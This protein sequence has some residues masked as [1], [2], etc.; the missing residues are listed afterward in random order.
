[1]V[2]ARVSTRGL[3]DEPHARL[4]PGVV[5]R[6]VLRKE[7]AVLLRGRGRFVDDVRVEGALEAAMLRSPFGHARIAHIDVSAAS[8]LPGVHVVVVAADLPGG[9]PPIPMRMYSRPGMERFL[10]RPLAATAVRYVG[11]PVAVVVADSRYL[12]EDALDLIEVDYEPL[13]A[14]VDAEAALAAGAPLLHAGAGT[15]LV[16]A[17]EIVHG[18][19][20]AAFAGAAHVV[21]AAIRC[22]RHAAVPL[23]TRGLLALVAPDGR[24][25]VHGPT[26][27][28]HTNRRILAG[29]L[30]WPEERIR[31]VE[32]HV[33]GGFG[34]RGEFYPEDYLV[35]FLAI[36]LGRPVKW[37]EDRAEALRAT[38]HSRDQLDRLFVALAAD[39]AFLGLRAELTLDT[40]AYVRTHGG[41]VPGLSA[42]LLP[43]PYAWPALEI[44]VR[45]VVT[46]KTPSGTYRGPGR[47]ETTLARER[48]VDTAAGRLGLDPAELRRRNLVRPEWMPWANGSE[49]DGHPIVYDTGDYPALLEQGL[50]RFG[51]DEQRLWRAAPPPPARRRG[52]GLAFFVEKSGIAHWEYARVELGVGGEPVVFTGAASVGQGLETVLAQLCADGL[53][54]PYESVSVRHGDTDE[55]PQGMGSFGSRATSLGGAAVAQAA[56]ALRLRVLGAAAAEL[57]AAVDDL[58]IVGASVR[59]RGVPARGVALAELARA[60]LSL[61]EE[62]VFRAEEMSYPYG[63]HCAAVEIDVE[64][65]AV[66]V[67]RYTVAYDVGRAINPVLVEGQIVGGLAQGLG[68]ALLEELAYDSDGQLVSGSF[69]D[70][71]LPTAVEVPRVDVLVSEDAPT[72]RSPIGA[73]G[74]GEGGA[75]ASGACLANAIADALGVAVTATPVTPGWIVE[76]ARGRAA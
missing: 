36:L 37:T 1:M 22:G 55:V 33:G 71:L 51:Y 23:E 63:L 65:G 57:E 11:E 44:R 46:N 70:Y 15:N 17:F 48:L 8:A 5:G 56:A 60:G 59:V 29:L 40:G 53:G 13:P 47:Y 27:I 32:P 4:R 43:G 41:V 54:V 73:K 26:K 3:S 49:A 45:Q 68:G 39:G 76:A 61:S 75:S 18:D 12:A 19:T 38:N 28:V 52:L 30:D 64:T 9:G 34:A 25:V 69:M 21:E 67:A 20:A 16:S 50:A 10:Q 14:V 42:A 7:D 2:I 72:P 58:E 62:N 74:A 35:P 6:S 66:E 31:F 24:L